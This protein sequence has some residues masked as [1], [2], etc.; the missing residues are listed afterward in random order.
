[1]NTQRRLRAAL[2]LTLVALPFGTAVSA[3][4][5]QRLTVPGINNF[6]RVDATV[7]TGGTITSRE[8]AIPELKRRGI[9]SVV[10][11]AGGPEAEAERA[12]VEQAGMKYF[13]FAINSQTLDPAPVDPFLKAA[14]DRTNYPLFIHSGNGH[15]AAMAWMI[16]RIVADGW[17]VE[18][19]GIEAASDGLIN[20]NPMTPVWWKFAQDYIAAHRK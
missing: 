16:K 13:L 20:D 2:V 4:G 7:S 5:L 3:Q 17:T 6:W 14:A 18:R 12:A 10:N 9:R 8:M 15:R 11:L 19:A 1:M